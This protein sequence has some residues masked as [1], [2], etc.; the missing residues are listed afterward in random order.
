MFVHAFRL[1]IAGDKPCRNT[2]PGEEKRGSDNKLIVTCVL[3]YKLTF[4]TGENRMS[5]SSAS[6]QSVDEFPITAR[7]I[8]H[9]D[10]ASIAEL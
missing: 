5:I 7:L 9:R 6:N 10:A 4:I 3:N 1:T 8:Y 2:K